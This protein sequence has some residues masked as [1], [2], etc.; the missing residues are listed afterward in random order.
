MDGR[1]FS[2]KA[3][4]TIALLATLGLANVSEAAWTPPFKVARCECSGYPVLTTS[5]WGG[6]IVA[7][8]EWDHA[9]IARRID[10]NGTLGWKRTLAER[11]R[12]LSADALDG[13]WIATG[14][15]G[16]TAM[17][18]ED[19]PDFVATGYIRAR[20]LTRRGKLGRIP[21][22]GRDVSG[23]IDPAVAVD[24]AGDATITWIPIIAPSSQDQGPFRN[25]VQARRLTARG[26]L[27]AT[28]DLSRDFSSPLGWNSS[29]RVAVAPSGRATVAWSSPGGAI[30]ATTIRRN[31]KVAAVRDVI[32]EA[33]RPELAV[34]AQGNAIVVWIGSAV[35]ARRIYAGGMLGPIH[36]LGAGSQSDTRPRVA[37]D[38]AGNASVVWEDSGTIRFRRIGKSETLGPVMNLSA[39]ALEPLRS[40]S[41]A[42]AVDSAGSAIAAWVGPSSGSTSYAIQARRV[43]PDGELGAIRELSDTSR[44][45]S[46]PK[47]VAD[48]RGVVTVAWSESRDQMRTFIR[49]AR[50]VQATRGGKR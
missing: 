16:A 12:L 9:L 35:M 44:L 46:R 8:Q 32:D 4:A 3:T 24:D 5:E 33:G 21:R 6:S 39:P 43:T 47:V 37:V 41:P 17:V 10:R 29:P 23:G 42:V 28:L 14:P 19:H 11:A 26:G 50:L 31:G 1:R 22:I 38:R 40:G 25:I 13:G 49:A 36:V 34:D 18:W 2:R 45:L 7:W 15:S 48:S 30:A 20:R 27:G